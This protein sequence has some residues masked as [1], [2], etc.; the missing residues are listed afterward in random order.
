[1]ATQRRLEVPDG[2][3][4]AI[5]DATADGVVVLDKNRAVMAANRSAEALFGYDADEMVNLP[6]ASLLAPDE[7]ARRARDL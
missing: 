1:M 6:F 3:L 7:P 2:T 4:R 5:L